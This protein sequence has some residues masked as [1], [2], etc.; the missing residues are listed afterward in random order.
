MDYNSPGSI[1]GRILL[2][3]NTLFKGNKRAFSQAVGVLP[4]VTENLVGRR[5]SAPSFE[6][7]SKII[8][9]LVNVN[10]EWFLTGKG[11][12]FNQPYDNKTNS[13]DQS[14]NTVNMVNEPV[15]EYVNKHEPQ[16]NLIKYYESEINK[17]DK[18]ID[19][20]DEVIRLK[21]EIIRSKDL[22]IELLTKQNNR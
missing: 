7:A 6:V 22:T 16:N 19:S 20:K 15:S 13:D 18:I 8:K 10:A 5:Q 9:S 21:D 3:I 17:R 1:N 11:E 12:M 14:Y 4:T 2:I